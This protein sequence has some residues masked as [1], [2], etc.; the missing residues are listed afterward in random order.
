MKTKQEMQNLL[1]EIEMT[2][3]DE[4]YQILIKLAVIAKQ[5]ADDSCDEN[6]ENTSNH[7]LMAASNVYNRKGN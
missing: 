4:Y 2:D 6:W 3:A 7:L 1:K 5:C